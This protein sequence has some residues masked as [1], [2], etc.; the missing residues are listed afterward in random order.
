VCATGLESGE[1]DALSLIRSTSTAVDKWRM[2]SMNVVM[3][4]VNKETFSYSAVTVSKCLNV[5]PKIDVSHFVNELLEFIR[6]ERKFVGCQKCLFVGKDS[7]HVPV[8]FALQFS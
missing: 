6:K 5:K 4:I 2:E 3:F 7:R 8:F 1:S